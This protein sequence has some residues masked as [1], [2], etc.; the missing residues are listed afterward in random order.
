[1]INADARVL[2]ISKAPELE[3]QHQI[4]I[5]VILRTLVLFEL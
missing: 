3:P 4:Q 1:M 5:S 2:Q